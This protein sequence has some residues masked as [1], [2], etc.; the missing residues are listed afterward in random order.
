MTIPNEY[1]SKFSH[2]FE[3]FDSSLKQLGISSYGISLSTLE[4][5]FL[6]VGKLDEDKNAGGKTPEMNESA[7]AEAAS[8]NMAESQLDTSFLNNFQAMMYQ[9]IMDYKRNKKLFFTSV[10]VPAMLLI[11][12]MGLAKIDRIESS[13]SRLQ[14]PD[15]LTM[16]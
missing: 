13:P 11:L 12:G 14:T 2:F 8:F 1:A 15:R 10:I 3:G 6:K 5:V 7:I 4:E 16:P 9:R